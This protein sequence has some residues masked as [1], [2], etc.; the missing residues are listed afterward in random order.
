MFGISLL[1]VWFVGGMCCD[2]LFDCGWLRLR[3]VVS[4]AC[5]FVGLICLVF[6][7][8]VGFV[9]FACCVFWVG[10]VVVY[11]CMGCVC[12]FTGLRLIVLV[13]LV[14]LCCIDF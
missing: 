4:C 10:L 13:W 14:L 12:L 1:L 8:L 9:W 3:F 7:T 6:L 5:V 2:C 11:I